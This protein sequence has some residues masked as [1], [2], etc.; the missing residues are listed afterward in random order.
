ML[1]A[2]VRLSAFVVILSA[3]TLGCTSLPETRP[4]EIE[5]RLRES[6]GMLPETTTIKIGSA[7][8]TFADRYHDAERS[9]EFEVSEAE[10]DALWEV[11]RKNRFDRIKTHEESVHDRGGT[12]SSPPASADPQPPAELWTRHAELSLG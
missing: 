4:A 8:G 9:I 6:A 10:L 1:P 5:I 12:E 3:M 2:P 7:G 11:L